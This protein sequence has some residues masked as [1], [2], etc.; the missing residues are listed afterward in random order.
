MIMDAELNRLPNTFTGS[1]VLLP[2]PL[3]ESC[4]SEDLEPELTKSMDRI[5]KA[6]QLQNRCGNSNLSISRQEP[7]E[8]SEPSKILTIK[9]SPLLS[10]P[11][12]VL[13]KRDNSHDVKRQ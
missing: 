4:T 6:A 5:R 3:F 13:M 12:R 7:K 2:V 9:N 8:P 1:G 11:L 10:R